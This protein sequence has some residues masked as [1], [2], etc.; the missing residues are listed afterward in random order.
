MSCVIGEM[1]AVIAKMYAL[2]TGYGTGTAPL[3]SEARSNRLT[4][5]VT[6]LADLLEE[7]VA[8]VQPP[9]L[10]PTLRRN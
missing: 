7:P 3:D 8:H 1:D 5:C 6:R 4:A 2:V 10:R 9:E